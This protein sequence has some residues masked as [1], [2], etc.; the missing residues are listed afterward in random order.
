MYFSYNKF[1]KQISDILFDLLKKESI[2]NI[3][4][5]YCKEE[6]ENEKYYIKRKINYIN[7]YIF[8]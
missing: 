4:T 8:L 7:Y 5:Y 1:N 3:L 2:I 6:N